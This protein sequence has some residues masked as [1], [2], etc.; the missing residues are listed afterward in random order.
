VPETKRGNNAAT[1]T[2][3]V[4]EISSPDLV[5]TAMSLKYNGGKNGGWDLHVTVKNSG[6]T[7]ALMCPGMTL[8]R[9]TATPVS[10][11]YGLQTLTFSQPSPA[12]PQPSPTTN[13]Q[14]ARLEW[15]LTPLMRNLV[16]APGES[17][18][19]FVLRACGHDDLQPGVYEWKVAVNPDGAIQEPNRANNE[20]VAQL[21][22]C[23]Y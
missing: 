11:K 12:A 10:S 18:S 13:Q 8:I 4:S 17:Y 20:G 15:D 6:S 5:V 22:G 19:D 16:I 7:P 9:E 21:Q 14:N 3:T 2:P 1:A 23:H